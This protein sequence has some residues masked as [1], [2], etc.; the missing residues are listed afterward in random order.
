MSCFGPGDAPN[1]LMTPHVAIQGNPDKTTMGHVQVVVDN[2]GLAM[3][4]KPL[5][6]VVDKV[7]RF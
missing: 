1:F 5:R 7:T 3:A 6:N 4:D 2:V